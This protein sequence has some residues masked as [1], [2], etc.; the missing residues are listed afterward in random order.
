MALSES[1][2]ALGRLFVAA[3]L[4]SQEET[5]IAITAAVAAGVQR[6][7]VD[8]VLLL[9]IAYAG[10]PRAILGFT[11][12]REV[13]KSIASP[14][15]IADRRKAGEKTFASVYGART[16]RIRDEL[17]ALHPVLLDAILEDSYGRILARRGLGAHDRELLA[18]AMLVGLGA[19][20]QA[21][22]HA[23]GA[24]R[25]KASLHDIL[26]AAD[27]ASTYVGP[28]DLVAAKIAITEVLKKEG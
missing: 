22:A 1:F 11:A 10:I 12:W 7:D 13:E 23:I 14:T 18:V 26:E 17:K 21:A 2:R 28:T 8:E 24:H 3:C 25:A 19:A 9:V 16:D 5:R 4:G 20:R 27:L 6:D 15:T